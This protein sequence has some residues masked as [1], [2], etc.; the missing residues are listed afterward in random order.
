MLSMV[1]GVNRVIVRGKVDV[2]LSE[3]VD[4][5]LSRDTDYGGLELLKSVARTNVCICFA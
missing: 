2:G 3:L 5:V 1:P 4:L